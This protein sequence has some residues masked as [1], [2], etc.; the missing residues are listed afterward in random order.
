MFSH[1]FTSR[2]AN[3]DQANER[4]DAADNSQTNSRTM[5]TVES[6]AKA[7]RKNTAANEIR[8]E[9]SHVFTN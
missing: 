5:A 2:L 4:H 9:L 1:V 3:E 7:S 6:I 8:I